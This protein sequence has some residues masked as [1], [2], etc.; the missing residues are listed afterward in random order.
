M[1]LAIGALLFIAFNAILITAIA[2]RSQSVRRGVVKALGGA[3][4][5]VLLEGMAN[6][7]AVESKGMLQVSGTGCLAMNAEEVLFV[8]WWP[9]R[10]FRIARKDI[11][12]V[13]TP[14]TFMGRWSGRPML[15]I[16]WKTA[17][18][19][20]DSAAWLVRTRDA[21]VRVLAAPDH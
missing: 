15:H 21:W 1:I 9:R 10:E 12:A 17:D 20:T 3:S 7:K 6:L 5:I 8:M 4:A 11:V 18:G 16:R 19:A 13:T 14:K 2:L